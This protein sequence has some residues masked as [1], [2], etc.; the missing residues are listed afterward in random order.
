MIEKGT[1]AVTTVQRV[2]LL[3]TRVNWLGTEASE[4]RELSDALY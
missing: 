2:R 1:K 4:L 3:S